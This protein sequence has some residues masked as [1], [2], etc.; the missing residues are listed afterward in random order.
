MQNRLH[1]ELGF[2]EDQ[3]EMKALLEEHCD[4]IGC[5]LVS[6]LSRFRK[7]DEPVGK[8]I[9]RAYEWLEKQACI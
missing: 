7:P 3:R 6:F 9:E 4:K 5:S 1:R 2:T 8:L